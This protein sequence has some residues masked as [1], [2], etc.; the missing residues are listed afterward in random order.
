M[1]AATFMGNSSTVG[2]LTILASILA[3]AKG[4]R[5]SAGL[6]ALTLMSLPIDYL[7]KLLWQ[8]AR[9][10]ES[11]VNVAVLTSGTSFPSGHAFAGTMFYGA[12]S[13]V[14]YIHL[15]KG[16]LRS[17]LVASLILLVAAIDASRV[18]LGA[19]WL[20]D[21]VGGT[22]IGLALLIPLVQGY[23]RR[24]RSDAIQPISQFNDCEAS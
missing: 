14:C 15:P 19:H 3:L 1:K 20:S 16:T 24:A 8:R 7:L 23:S 17:G 13:A 2:V 18:Y 11:L 6:I 10:D 5:A 21:V 12:L 9:P 4:L 22:C